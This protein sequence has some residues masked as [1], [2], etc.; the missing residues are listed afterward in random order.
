M[1]TRKVSVGGG[2][3]RK[4]EQ[5]YRRLR[6]DFEKMQNKK[7][8]HSRNQEIFI[9]KGARCTFWW[10]LRVSGCLLWS[11]FW[12]SCIFY[13][14]GTMTCQNLT[15]NGNW[16]GMLTIWLVKVQQLTKENKDM[17]TCFCSWPVS[18]LT[19]K[20]LLVYAMN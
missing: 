15:T 19:N 18:F 6:L 3:L 7:K 13:F 16:T 9:S 11:H 2:I 8:P 5:L 12:Q 14:R 20:Q 17:I 1:E 4:L 10:I